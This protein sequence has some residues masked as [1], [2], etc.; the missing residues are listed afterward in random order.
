MLRIR[1]FC[2]LTAGLFVLALS[3][4][5]ASTLN[6]ITEPA[7]GGLNMVVGALLIE[8]MGVD[9]KSETLSGKVDVYLVGKKKSDNSIVSY[10]LKTDNNGYFCVENVPAGN[11]LIKGVRVMVGSKYEAKVV[12]DLE[13]PNS[14]Y[15]LQRN[16]Q[17]PIIMEAEWLPKQPD[18]RVLDLGFLYIGFQPTG[19]EAG[20]SYNLLI[21]NFDFA[22]N[23]ELNLGKTYNLVTPFDYFKSKFPESPWFKF[24]R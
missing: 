3:G 24:V 7:S 13:L 16:I 18:D 21:E 5:G 9:F 2:L 17:D 15:Y 19:G 4:C 11:Y 10:K 8:N 22:D 1:C 12:N 20:L 6:V 14:G 23:K